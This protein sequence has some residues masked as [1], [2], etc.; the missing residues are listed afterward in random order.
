MSEDEKPKRRIELR[1]VTDPERIAEVEAEHRGAMS[2]AVIAGRCADSS[3]AFGV[4]CTREP[5]HDGPHDNGEWQWGWKPDEPH[6]LRPL[7]SLS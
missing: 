3:Q 1:P 6:V 4:V 7:P 2:D 5:G